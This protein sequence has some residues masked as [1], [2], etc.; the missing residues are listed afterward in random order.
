MIQNNTRHNIQPFL[1]M[2]NVVDA[3]PYP[4]LGAKGYSYKGN[5]DTIKAP[6]F[7]K[8][9][10]LQ[11]TLD[12]YIVDSL[13]YKK[14][15]IPPKAVEDFIISIKNR[16]KR[17]GDFS[18]FNPNNAELSRLYK[19]LYDLE[20]NKNSDGSKTELISRA[21]CYYRNI[22][23]KGEIKI[24]Y[25]SDTTEMVL[26]YIHE[27]MHAYYDTSLLKPVSIEF[28]EEPLA[29]L[30]KL[31][32]CIDFDSY[33]PRYPFSIYQS[34]RNSV[35]RSQHKLGVGHYGFG[36]F[37]MDHY[38]SIPW[39][40]I[41]RSHHHLL[42][43][44]S[45]YTYLESNLILY[46]FDNG[47][48][49]FLADTLFRYIL[50]PT[51][52][53]GIK[54]PIT[55]PQLPTVEGVGGGRISYPHPYEQNH[56]N[57]LGG[58]YYERPIDINSKVVEYLV[59]Q[60]DP[61]HFSFPNSTFFDPFEQNS[62]FLKEIARRIDKALQSTEPNAQKRKKIIEKRVIGYDGKNSST[63]L[64]D[65]MIP[66]E[67]ELWS[68]RY[69]VIIGVPPFYERTAKNRKC[70]YLPIIDEI[71]RRSHGALMLFLTPTNWYMSQD[72]NCA[73]YR[74]KVIIPL[75]EALY[76]F[77]QT[78]DVFPNENFMG[79]VAAMM[80]REREIKYLYDYQYATI[81]TFPSNIC[82]L[83]SRIWCR[84]DDLIRRGEYYHVFEVICHRDNLLKYNKYVDKISIQNGSYASWS[85]KNAKHYSKGYVIQSHV[86]GQSVPKSNFVVNFDPNVFDPQAVEK[87]F[88]TKLVRYLVYNESPTTSW[89]IPKSAFDYIPV[90]LLYNQNFA[91]QNGIPMPAINWTAPMDV[92][93]QAVY[94]YYNLPQD[95][96][97]YIEHT[98]D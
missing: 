89:G 88:Q 45:L 50:Y 56:S 41:L 87:F 85:I 12:V 83:G 62:P 32:F 15:H 25:N 69:S 54:N 43:H 37:L 59:N 86:P 64:S 84:E 19:S 27:M 57:K 63:F 94:A 53:N 28:A 76:D 91:V 70:I 95:L 73:E 38:A 26:T 36:L 31:K 74:N 8:L 77:Y 82:P 66:E 93:N 98:I 46:P 65:N 92:I 2:V 49:K 97:D 40:N 58:G 17:L 4:L 6:Y 47:K 16:I 75:M 1:D 7:A 5:K 20:Q 21:G 44:N 90:D 18:D 23:N 11:Q 29:E 30:G 52:P 34:S 80:L 14:M 13:P 33:R 81:P 3:H 96:I 67:Q 71:I 78:K 61:N 72:R 9:G 10:Q 22:N 51:Y 48:L 24:V 35:E 68:K 39:E 42:Q 55:L 60:I 79:G